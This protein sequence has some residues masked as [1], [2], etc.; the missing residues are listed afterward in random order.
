MKTKEMI[1]F[2]ETLTKNQKHCDYCGHTISFHSFEPDKKIC[3]H[4]QHL[5]YRNEL[6]KFKDKINKKMSEVKDEKKS[7]FNCNL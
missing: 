4:C 1:K 3:N 5:N 7:N 2:T 6:V